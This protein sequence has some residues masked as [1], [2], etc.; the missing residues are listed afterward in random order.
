MIKIAH[1]SDVHFRS[2][3]RHEE[4]KIVFNKVFKSLQKENVDLIF[5]GGD[6][7]HSK[8]QG[9]TPEIID[10]LNWWFTSLANIAPTHIILG[11]HDGLILNKDRQDAISP[12][13]AALDNPRLFLYKNS[14]VYPCKDTNINWCVF[15]CFDEENWKNVKPTKN[16]INIACF[17][18]AVWGSKTDVDWEL[19]G[20]VNTD[21]FNS[22]DF[23]F[24]G[25]IHKFQYLDKEKRIAYPGSTVQQ[26][27]GED[28]KKGYL[29]WTINSKN[30]Y[31]SKFISI[32]NPHPHVTIDW[33]EN[34]EN[35][36]K[37]CEKVKSK[38]RFR[39]RSNTQISQAEIKILHHYLKNDKKAKEVV[40]QNIGTVEKNIEIEFKNDSN[41]LDIRNKVDR[42][43]IISNFYED[44][45]EENTNKILEIFAENLDK[46]P[47]D[48]SDKIGN[49]W[50]I[51]SIEFDNTF[52]YGK[53][54]FIN[55]D[56]LTGIVGLF[57]SNRSG[58]SSIPG[59]LMYTLFNSTDRGSL[60][61]ID[62]INT[63]KGFCTGN[64][65]FTVNGEK[66]NISRKT[67]KR[68]NKKGET[69]AST[70]LSLTKI[71]NADFNDE[72][73]EQR[74]ETQKN[75][76]SLIG[77]PEDFL[78]TSFA[79]QG[80]INSFIK[81]KSTARKSIL[82]KF[83]NIDVYDELYKL[84]R[85]NYI[86][87]KNKI[88]NLKE[89][90]WDLEIKDL[91][92]GIESNKK[93]IVE[94][95]DKL[96][97]LREEEISLKLQQKDL[98]KDSTDKS[99]YTLDSVGKEIVHTK[100]KA[101]SLI[102][103]DYHLEQKISENRLKLSKID[104]FK[105][106]FSLD[107]LK[108]DE[109]KLD[110]LL[111]K[112]SAFNNEKNSL[113][114]D[115]KRHQSEIK[116]LDNV[117]CENK[118]KNCMFIKKAFDSKEQIEKVS[119][120]IKDIEGS[121]YEIKG[122]VKSLKD[123]EIKEKIQKYNEILLKEEKIKS[124]IA[125]SITKKDYVKDKITSNNEKLES[126]L[127]IQERIKNN[128]SIKSLNK[129]EEIK[130]S[131]KEL[132]LKVFDIEKLININNQNIFMSERDID[133]LIKEKCE[134]NN[135]VDE[136][137]VYDLYSFAVSKKGIPTSIIKSVLPRINKEI[138]NILNGVTNFTITLE[139]GS[140]N[141][142]LEV[143]IDYGDSKRV[144]ECASGMEKMLASIAIRVSLINISSLPKSDIFII[145]EGFGALDDNN[146]E[147]CGRLLTSLKKY[148]KTIL[149]ISHVDAIKDI[150]DKNLEIT[151][152][153][154]DSYVYAK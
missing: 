114:K 40:F 132:D 100:E 146:V 140:S 7:V 21:F 87:L 33:Q 130:L 19:E 8:T 34:L 93:N 61:N 45:S 65:N 73:E 50:S 127:E 32:A 64:L 143:Y 76:K 118:F 63:R 79:S 119:V 44:L 51:N 122:L 55:F 22:F 108:Q 147:A 28:V 105:E 117:P 83:L 82:T 89:K 95:K 110:T 133:A 30:D 41:I 62:V 60:K 13:I 58:K 141:N 154:K 81:E 101:K 136:W 102:D 38:S 9:I 16:A 98:L 103:N 42:Q 125:Q 31:N 153:N 48:L 120:D 144:I 72:T 111:S 35:T 23:G 29:L 53:S 14:G 131:I 4:Y 150:V 36:F 123:Q 47:E 2:L 115:Y 107:K 135:I 52:S 59:T 27:Y 86:V 56:N 148:F 20:E 106:S 126:L 151:I 104:S 69:S 57:G 139:E 75:I 124:E 137:K 10:L 128:N 96:S 11:N 134:F 74:R 152:K 26:N 99:G 121:I 84:S 68:T 54:N 70:S 66:Y 25:D 24:L 78:S 109:E 90:N 49:R 113:N 6:I 112:L 67:E 149:I 116:I 1:I 92:L 39:I 94:L 138:A 43:K 15:S 85:E 88:K 18:G 12:I 97:S 17:H 129:L 37:Y 5:V 77:S 3:K 46:L 71:N 91:R 145:D 142:N 80:E